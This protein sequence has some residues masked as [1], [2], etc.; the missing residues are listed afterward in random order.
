MDLQLPSD[1][2]EFLALLNAAQIEYLL[3]GGYAVSYYGYPRPTGDM[4][5]WV[6]MDAAK[7]E[8]LAEVVKAFGFTSVTSASFLKPGNIV[9]MGVPPMRIEVLNTLSGVQF[10][11]SYIR[12][13][14][15]EIDGLTVPVMARE[16]LL[17]NKA[18]AGRLKDLND[19]EHLSGDGTK[20]GD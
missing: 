3:V 4:D 1:F 17:R 15:A 18:A 13:E 2:K 14:I 5:V 6:A 10:G 20:D 7:A 16:D 11:P 9:R 8:K 19:L 12:R